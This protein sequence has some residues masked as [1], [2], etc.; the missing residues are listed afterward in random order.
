MRWQLMVEQI[1]DMQVDQLGTGQ[2]LQGGLD[3]NLPGFKFRPCA[4]DPD[5]ALCGR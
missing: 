5:E 1:Q 4:G 2:A 3:F